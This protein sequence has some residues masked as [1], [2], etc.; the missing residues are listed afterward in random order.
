M[1]M[2]SLLR[3]NESSW[4]DRKDC[5]KLRITWIV[6]SGLLEWSTPSYGISWATCKSKWLAGFHASVLLLIMNFVT[7]LWQNSMLL[8]EQTHE[9][10]TSICLLL[11]NVLTLVLWVYF[12]TI[13]FFISAP[14][15]A[16][17]NVNGVPISADSILVQ[18]QVCTLA[19]LNSININLNN[20]KYQGHK[21]RIVYNRPVR[22]V[23]M[24]RLISF[25]LL[26]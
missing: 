26:P 8:T 10:L 12:V 22:W 23:F 9:K 25:V 6:L 1:E 5:C 19:F 16:P 24:K 17:L 14:S 11:T 13:F 4:M 7:M 2:K 15:A 20:V 18:W 3:S 21:S